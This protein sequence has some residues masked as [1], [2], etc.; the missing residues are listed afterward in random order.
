[1]DVVIVLKSSKNRHILPNAICS[2]FRFKLVIMQEKA[3]NINL[4]VIHLFLALT[5][6]SDGWWNSIAFTFRQWHVIVTNGFQRN[7]GRGLELLFS[8]GASVVRPFPSLVSHQRATQS[9]WSHASSNLQIYARSFHKALC[10]SFTWLY[11]YSRTFLT[12]FTS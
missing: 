3:G 10:I 12:K 8:M 7:M 11:S 5:L 6:L 2:L 4:Y 9:F 1:M